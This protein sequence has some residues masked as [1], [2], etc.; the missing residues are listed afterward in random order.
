MV[1]FSR[2]D[3]FRQVTVFFYMVFSSAIWEEII[4][5]L[6]WFIYECENASFLTDLISV[7]AFDQH[8]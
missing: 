5:C 6:Y 7:H 3:V 4:L 8:P 1:P 2:L